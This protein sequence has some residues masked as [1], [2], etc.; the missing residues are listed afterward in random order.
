MS[1]KSDQSFKGRII[2]SYICI[3]RTRPLFPHYHLCFKLSSILGTKEGIKGSDILKELCDVL[4]ATLGPHPRV[5]VVV[6]H[7]SHHVLLNL[8]SVLPA[9]KAVVMRHVE[10]SKENTKT[11]LSATQTLTLLSC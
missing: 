10:P 6:E 1:P 8:N 2:P 11:C 9:L 5:C 4:P 7:G 3:F